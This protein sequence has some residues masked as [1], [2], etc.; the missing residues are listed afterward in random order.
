MLVMTRLF[1][2]RMLLQDLTLVLILTLQQIE[3]GSFDEI[4]QIR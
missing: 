4:A 1:L 3:F 2:E